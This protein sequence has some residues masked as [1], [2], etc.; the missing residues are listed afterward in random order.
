MLRGEAD[1]EARN[2]FSYLQKVRALLTLVSTSDLNPML[3]E[4]PII[5]RENLNQNGEETIVIEFWPALVLI[6]SQQ[7]H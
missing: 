5:K 1:Q 7:G 2:I 4:V 3:I 6:K